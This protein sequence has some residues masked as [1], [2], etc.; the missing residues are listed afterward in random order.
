M[1]FFLTAS[2]GMLCPSKQFKNFGPSFTFKVR[3]ASGVAN[4]YHNYMLPITQEER[5]FFLTG[6]RSTVAEPFRYLHIPADKDD[7]IN[8]FMAFHALLHDQAKVKRIAQSSVRS[9]M[10]EVNKKDKRCAM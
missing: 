6:M 4:E 7:S 1:F 2:K 5:R 10:S 8:R 3:D 9:A